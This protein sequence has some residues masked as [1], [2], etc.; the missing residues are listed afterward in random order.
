M[1]AVTTAPYDRFADAY[2]LWW[3]PVLGPSARRV[4]EPIAS[5][6]DRGPRSHLVD[7]GV[8]TGTVVLE[9]LRR[10]P[11][12]RVTGV[13]EADE[14]LTI[15]RREAE[16]AGHD[17]SRRLK[18]VRGDALELPIADA[19]AD[20]AVS[21]FVVQ[22]VDS[23]AAMLREARRILRPQGVFAC[24]T[25]LAENYDF[26]PD[27]AFDDALDELRIDPPPRGPSPRPYG[28]TRSAAAELRKAGFRS[29]RAEEVWLEHQWDADS[30]VGLLE[31]WAEEDLFL[32]L[33][34]PDRDRLR[35]RTRELLG[36]LPADAFRWRR[37]LTL[38]V[39]RADGR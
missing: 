30:Y 38:V 22:L 15:A 36:R 1:T 13:D 29:V 16:R 6:L 11:E 14:M 27:R 32:S 9:V 20:L 17:I 21:T 4:I 12:V 19:S 8:G 33:A 37:P 7:I 24:L 34:T 23:R 18:L 5:E 2:H 35:R 10:W 26:E 25:W 28:S 39:G 31:H 3:G